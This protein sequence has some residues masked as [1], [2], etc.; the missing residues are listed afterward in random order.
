MP[1]SGFVV[2]Q[3]INFEIFIFVSLFLRGF[4]HFFGNRQIA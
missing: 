2:V 4:L 3:L 1:P